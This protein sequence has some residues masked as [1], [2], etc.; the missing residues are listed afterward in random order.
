MGSLESTISPTVFN[1]MHVGRQALMRLMQCS[2]KLQ[3]NRQL[4]D[5]LHGTQHAGKADKAYSRGYW[6]ITVMGF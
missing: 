5:L 6:K 4:M 3:A 1:A 2:L